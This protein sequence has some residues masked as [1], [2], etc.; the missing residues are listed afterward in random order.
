VNLSATAPELDFLE[1]PIAHGHL[2][3]REITASKCK[4]CVRCPEPLSVASGFIS[5][6]V[7]TVDAAQRMEDLSAGVARLPLRLGSQE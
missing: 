5:I 3:L 2:H 1:A 7:G 6:G 4:S